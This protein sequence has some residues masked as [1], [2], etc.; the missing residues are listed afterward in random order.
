M[1][2]EYRTLNHL[3]NSIPDSEKR[4]LNLPISIVK[5]DGTI[6]LEVSDDKG[7]QPAAYTG[8]YGKIKDAIALL[9]AY[10]EQLERIEDKRFAKA[11]QIKNELFGGVELR[12]IF[13]NIISSPFMDWGRRMELAESLFSQ[14]SNYI[15]SALAED[16]KYQ[17][18]I[19][20]PL[21]AA[22]KQLEKM[23]HEIRQNRELQKDR[24]EM[25]R[26]SSQIKSIRMFQ[27]MHTHHNVMCI[28][29]VRTNNNTSLLKAL[30]TLT[31]EPDCEFRQDHDLPAEQLLTPE[32]LAHYARLKPKT[33]TKEQADADE[34][35]DVIETGSPNQS[36]DKPKKASKQRGRKPKY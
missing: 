13:Q 23:V 2:F 11:E 29:C 12:Q 24:D 14:S 4:A 15:I 28:F 8:M 17:D 26:R 31:H 32:I 33:P 27:P 16:S 7:N 21:K 3:A 22:A 20:G 36:N 10:S 6:V 9:L 5:P 34:A 19:A 30:H 35:L 1:A 25:L 18:K